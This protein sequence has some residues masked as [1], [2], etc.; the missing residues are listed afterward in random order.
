MA[1][2]PSTLPQQFEAGAGVSRQQGFV[3]S[4]V[5]AGPFKQRKRYTAVSR[6]YTGTMLMT[7]TQ[8]ATLETFYT[9]TVNEG[10]DEFDFEDPVDFSTVSARFAS[11]PEDRG[12]VGGASGVA[13]WRVSFTLE[14]LP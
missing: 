2:W 6:F 4:P 9:T 12:I 10:A 1:T 7:E 5:S 14:I 13:L 11:A 3:R 8:R